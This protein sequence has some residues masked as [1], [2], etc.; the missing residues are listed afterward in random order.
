MKI[1]DMLEMCFVCGI[2]RDK[3]DKT[4][5]GFKHHYK[6]EHNMWNYVYYYAYLCYKDT[7]DHTGTETFVNDKIQNFDFEWFPIKRAF[8]IVNENESELE[9]QQLIKDISS[10]MGAIE[11]LT[12]SLL[13]KMNKIHENENE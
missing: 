6:N 8:S 9:K 5:T 10:K 11:S 3:L 13:T 12:S 7:N 4:A 1:E 2:N